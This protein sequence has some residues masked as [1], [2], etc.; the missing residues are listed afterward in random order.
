MMIEAMAGRRSFLVFIYW[1]LDSADPMFM[2][3]KRYRTIGATL[4]I[5]FQGRVETYSIQLSTRL[6]YLVQVLRTYHYVE[7]LTQEA[8]HYSIAW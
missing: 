7:K 4:L 6:V 1:E 8:W 3:R 5:Q 2:K